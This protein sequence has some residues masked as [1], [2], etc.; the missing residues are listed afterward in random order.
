MRCGCSINRGCVHPECGQQS[1]T[2][3]H[4][5]IAPRSSW[6]ERAGKQACRR[7]GRD[8]HWVAAVARDFGVGW[9]HGDGRRHRLRQRHTRLTHTSVTARSPAGRSRTHVG[10]RPCSRACAPPT[11]HQH[12]A[13]AVSI[14]YSTSPSRSETASTAMLSSP[15]IAVALLLSL[16]WGLPVRVRKTTN[17]EAP[18]PSAESGRQPCPLTTTT[19]HCEDPDK[20]RGMRWPK[21]AGR[22]TRRYRGL[23]RS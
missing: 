19:F 17:H 23:D 2:E 11:G 20:F 1:W 10:R 5:A 7:V 13:A 15:S 14:A 3:T 6:T 9:G 8:G 4:P 21:C 16:T 22:D 12:V 18:G